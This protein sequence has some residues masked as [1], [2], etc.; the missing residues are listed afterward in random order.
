MPPHDG[1]H[2]ISSDIYSVI[3][4]NINSKLTWVALMAPFFISTGCSNDDELAI[5]NITVVEEGNAKPAQ[6]A[7]STQPTAILGSGGSMGQQLSETFTNIVEPTKAKQ[8][9]VACSDLDAYEEDLVAAYK[10]GILITIVD[11][12]GSV[13]E[14]WCAAKGMVFTGD[15]VAADGASI[16]SFNKKAVSMSVQKTE[17]QKLGSIAIEEDEVPLVIFT[18]WLDAIL[19]PNLKGPD[20]RS[21][22]IRKRFSPQRV[23]HIF[24]IDISARAVKESGWGVPENISLHTT[25]EL[26]CDV[27]PLHSFADNVSFTGDIYAVEA[28]LTIHNGNLYNGRWQYTQGGRQY[29]STGFDLS[30]CKLGIG[31]LERT[32][33]GLSHSGT[34]T[35]AAGPAPVSTEAT[36]SLQ[37]GFEWSFDGWIT[38][39]NG[40]ESSTPTPIQEGGWTWNNLTESDSV[41]FEVKAFTDGGDMIWTL[42]ADEE[43]EKTESAD[44]TFRCSWIWMVPQAKDDTDGRYYMNVDMTPVYR[45][46]RNAVSGGRTES[47]DISAEVA[48]ARFMLIPPSRKEGQR[49]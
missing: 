16:I 15:P 19:T 10:R 2:V 42:S 44:L 6:K 9:I 29:E 28:E 18:G 21:K 30:S 34:H 32:P 49:I 35:L 27:Y 43:S 37:T 36:A 24:P 47:K 1:W 26:S 4:M 8:V 33:S 23:S 11:P 7:E 45:L 17:K 38:G 3:S 41:G 46:L 31:L 13:V 48:T 25:A 14:G 12:V 40:L 20:F 5:D 39:G 22:D